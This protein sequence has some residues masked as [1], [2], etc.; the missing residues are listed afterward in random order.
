M[1]S[2]C[3]VEQRH[4]PTH[5]L[6]HSLVQ[7]VP[8]ADSTHSPRDTRGPGSAQPPL[9]WIMDIVS[10]MSEELTPNVYSALDPCSEPQEVRDDKTCLFPSSRDA[11][12]R[13]G[14]EPC[15]NRACR[16]RPEW[17]TAALR[18]GRQ[19]SIKSTRHRMRAV[20]AYDVIFIFTRQRMRSAELFG[21][22]PTA[23]RGQGDAITDRRT[24]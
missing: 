1:R 24:D 3:E 4:S 16:I 9:E 12:R 22:K 20:A 2:N 19:K 21:V 14:P 10:K 18:K 6:T 23:M 7:R 5:S 17:R 15:G 8:P 13:H 11:K